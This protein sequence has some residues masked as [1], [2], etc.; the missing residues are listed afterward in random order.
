[1][2]KGPIKKDACRISRNSPSPFH[3]GF[4][5]VWFHVPCFFKKYKGALT[6]IS[7]LGGYEELRVDDQVKI[8][9]SIKVALPPGFT[10]PE[11]ASSAVESVVGAGAVDA[12]N[13]A[14]ASE[15]NKKLWAL[16]DRFEKE[17]VS[18]KQ[19]KAILE[20]NKMSTVGGRNDLVNRVSDAMIFGVATCPVCEQREIVFSLGQYLCK[21]ETTFGACAYKGLARASGGRIDVVPIVADSNSE[22]DW[23]KNWNQAP[24]AREK[25]IVARTAIAE[26]TRDAAQPLRSMKFTAIGDLERDKEALQS[27][28]VNNGGSFAEDIQT[29][30][31]YVITTYEDYLRAQNHV[32]PQE[33]ASVVDSDKVK[34]SI[35][36]NSTDRASLA[37][38]KEEHRKYRA[39][40]NE[41]L[42]QAM[43]MR[44]ALVSEPLL[45]QLLNTFGFDQSVYVIAGNLPPIAHAKLATPQSVFP[46]LSD[47]NEKASGISIS[48]GSENDANKP[49]AAAT[50]AAPA[51][52]AP[53]S[54]YGKP[55]TASGAMTPRGIVDLEAK[56]PKG[57]VYRELKPKREKTA[58]E[59]AKEKE[60]AEKFDP[61]S[62]E[63]M[64]EKKEEGP[65]K[66][67]FE[68]YD[69]MLSWTDVA[70]N[71][72][73]WYRLQIVD[74]NG[75]GKQFVFFTRWGRV[76]EDGNW[77]STPKGGLAAAKDAWAKK[78]KDKTKN[79]WKDRDNFVKKPGAYFPIETDEA[80]EEEEKKK[81]SGNSED[82]NDNDSGDQYASSA[83][84][85]PSFLEPRLKSLIDLIFDSN[86]LTKN[87]MD[88]RIDVNK[89][90]LGKLNR[91][92]VM[93]AYGV[94]KEIETALLSTDATSRL[95]LP[96][97]SSK[98]YT[99]IPHSFGRSAPEL[100]DNFSILRL[101]MKQLETLLDIM[102][103][104]KMLNEGAPL[105]ASNP[106]DTNYKK[107]G[108]GLEALNSYTREYKLVQRFVNTGYNPKTLGTSL[109]LQNVFKVERPG[110]KDAFEP[111]RMVRPRKLLWHG[112][113]TCN[114]VGILNSGLRIAP[115]EAPA[116]GYVFGKAIYL[117]DLI[118]KSA[119]YC[120]PDA[121]TGT[122]LLLLCDTA[123]GDAL[124]L[125]KP[126]YITSLPEGKSSAK[127][128]AKLQPDPTKEETG[129]DK[130]LVPIG[131]PTPTNLPDVFLEHSEYMVY[132]AAQI[133][134]RY[135]VQI[136]F[137]K[138]NQ[139][140]APK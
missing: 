46:T 2:C 16:K 87:M 63:S 31:D 114:F 65:Q 7:Q 12:E 19:L 111:F 33:T 6:H 94:L 130:V 124:A 91:G 71:L 52:A 92:M 28:I 82:G 32:L 139:L 135:L 5:A 60:E 132:D 76:G 89:M 110:E 66:G 116:S 140:V 44:L 15:N 129:D 1:M 131:A 133:R 8:S 22:I 126:E 58:E 35:S 56:C 42:K 62:F 108:V 68:L 136:K 83:D 74:V 23:I 93:A 106:S 38:Q 17:E 48:G 50:V 30:I 29:D 84:D 14:I 103:A 109:T 43:D 54:Y 25:R 128:L 24:L 107:L 53:K 122:G 21:A 81:K 77:T 57:V 123:L 41:K 34:S 10:P 55:P 45:D 137:E 113:R 125:S 3:D 9:E 121:E 27:I 95:K 80:D 85:T 115:P 104:A 26:Y 69:R 49:I 86:M 98:F 79:E 72:N 18:L 127:A 99:L 59:L 118:E 75:D 120:C 119:P 100:L 4:V 36:Q 20:L 51:A 105:I 88:L 97:L 39:N 64:K 102:I 61:T 13:A 70:A 90:P 134:I 101:K 96:A 73:K 78:W 67:D 11:A 37:E 40:V 138:V 112:S 117:S 47:L